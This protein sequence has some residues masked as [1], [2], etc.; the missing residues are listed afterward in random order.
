MK[1]LTSFFALVLGNLDYHQIFVPDPKYVLGGKR[2]EGQKE[3]LQLLE[4]NKKWI[5]GNFLNF[6]SPIFRF[7]VKDLKLISKKQVFQIKKLSEI[8][9]FFL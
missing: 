9:G 6:R 3:N 2:P 7:L 5:A 4:A 8:R 1:L